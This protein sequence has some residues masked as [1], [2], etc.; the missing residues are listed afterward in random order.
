MERPFEVGE[1]I[2]V[3]GVKGEVKEVNWRSAHIEAFGGAIQV[4]PNSTLN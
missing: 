3:S 2:E 1:M 4:V